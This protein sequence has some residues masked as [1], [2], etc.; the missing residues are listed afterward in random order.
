MLCGEGYVLREEILRL[1]KLCRD[2][3][4]AIE[5]AIKRINKIQ[6]NDLT[7]ENIPILTIREWLY[8]SKAKV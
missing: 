7:R 3:D 8:K 6:K 5:R 2:K 4:V 1:Q